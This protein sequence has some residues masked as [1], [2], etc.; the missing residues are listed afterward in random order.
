MLTGI[1]LHRNAHKGDCRFPERAL[2]MIDEPQFGAVMVGGLHRGEVFV[3]PDGSAVVVDADDQDAPV[4]VE[5]AGNSLG[6]GELYLV[7][8]LAGEQIDAGCGLELDR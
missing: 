8:S 3:Q 2:K 4:S 6:Y 5:K 7:V 1:R